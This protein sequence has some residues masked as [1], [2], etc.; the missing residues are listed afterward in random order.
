MTPE[1]IDELIRQQ[2]QA[3][4]AAS[5]KYGVGDVEMAVIVE[6]GNGML[7]SRRK[8]RHNRESP[9]E[10]APPLANL[11]GGYANQAYYGKGS[12]DLA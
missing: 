10:K 9:D 11:E 4:A 7:R 8:R 12:E 3:Y 1:E 6:T 5:A 2:G